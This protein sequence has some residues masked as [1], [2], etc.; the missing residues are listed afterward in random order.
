M[1]L[2]KLTWTDVQAVNILRRFCV[3]I[4]TSVWQ[5]LFWLLQASLGLGL[6]RLWLQMCIMSFW[7]VS[8]EGHSDLL[9]CSVMLMLFRLYS[10]VAVAK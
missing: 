6:C 5:V 3:Q 10:G 1:M 4:C 2:Q 8:V 9:A 7:L